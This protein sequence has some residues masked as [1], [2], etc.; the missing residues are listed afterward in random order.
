MAVAASQKTVA[1]TATLLTTAPTDNVSGS[2]V[3]ACNRHA[4]VVSYV[5][6]S[7]VTTSTGFKLGVGD[8]IAVDLAPGEALYGIVASGTGTVHVLE[9]GV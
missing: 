7:D 4:S 8:S 2:S 5:G 1:A 6:P 3:L 9:A